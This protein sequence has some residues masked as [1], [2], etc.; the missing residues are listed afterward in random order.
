MCGTGK[1]HNLFK[2]VVANPD[3]AYV[4][5]TP[6]LTEVSTRPAEE[7]AKF[8]EKGIVFEEATGEGYRTKGDHLLALLAERKNV[9]CTHAL[10]QGVGRAGQSSI[11]KHGY[12][13]VMDEE[14]G[15]IEPLNDSDLARED[16]EVL[17]KERVIVTD[18]DGRVRWNNAAWGD[19]NSAFSHVRTLAEEGALY[20]DKNGTFFNV[21]VPIELLSS[22]KRVIVATYLFEGSVLQALLKIK[23]IGCK[24][25]VFDGLQLRDEAILKRALKD[26]I[27]MFE[28]PNT[29]DKLLRTFKVPMDDLRAKR[30]AN[31][32]SASWYKNA[33]KEH[34]AL[35][36]NHLRNVAR[37][38][39]TSAENLM[40]TLPSTVAGKSGDKWI[41]SGAKVLKVKG[42]APQNCFLHK[43]A[44]ATN[45][46]VHKTAAI[47][48]Y[49]RYAHPAV[50]RYL[51]EQGAK[52]DQD[53]FA[54]AEM[55]QWFFR[56]A[57]RIPDGP[58]VRLHILSP[59]MAHLFKE[60][61]DS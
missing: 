10:F 5:V 28:C 37:Q 51:E 45:D 7:L 3:E 38:M 42:Y 1:T 53:N 26:R 4:Y 30:G 19:G 40:Y 48:A 55:I 8:P 61:L 35:I 27:E 14:L 49:N 29:T 39:D 56:T 44:R 57:I 22:A 60:W 16:R 41:K 11:A 18:D 59:R 50:T 47:H 34:I 13:I 46:Y 9:I 20:S 43:G 36:G 31:T 23:G 12:V 15:M 24:S 32:F 21:Q 25:F 33:K 54:L 2:F 6:M 58:K 17:V 52:V